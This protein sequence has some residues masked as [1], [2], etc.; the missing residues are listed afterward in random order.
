VTVLVTG[1]SGFVGG[2]LASELER[3]AIAFRALPRREIGPRTDWSDALRGID[4][5]V[6]LAALA[7]ERAR[8]THSLRRVNALGAERLARCAAQAG[9]RQF[10]FIST[11]GVHGDETHGTPFSEASALEPRS[12]YAAS[13]LEA[14][15]LLARLP[16]QV[17][18]LRPTLVYGPR[19]PG[20]FL[21]L[22]RWVDRGWPL[23]LASVTNRRNL[24]YVGNLVAAIAAA[25]SRDPLGGTFIVCDAEPVSTPSL[26]RGLAAG[27]ERGAHLLPFPPGALR[28]AARGLGMSDLARRILGSL[29]A[30]PSKLFHALQWRPPFAPPEALRE[31]ARWYR[32]A[33]DAPS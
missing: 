19:N 16:L 3:R 5:I 33:A 22:L 29:E 32:A 25:L 30:D 14:E 15:Q 17:T 12:P 7:H 24:T 20:N 8:D 13:K 10:I 31:T 28:F 1:A 2:H 26:I 18:V 6:H 23:P 27:L 9:V 4:R 21:R 11:I